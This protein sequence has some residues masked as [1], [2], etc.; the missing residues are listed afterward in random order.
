M[1]VRVM[2]WIFDNSPTQYGSR[3]VLLALADNA[4]DDGTRAF[5]SQETLAQKARLSI[6]QVRRCLSEL[7]STGAI[8]YVGLSPY[9]TDEYRVLMRDGQNVP[10]TYATESV[11]YAT[12]SVSHMSAKPSSKPSVKPSIEFETFWKAYPNKHGK[13]LAR[14]KWATLSP[15]EQ[16]KAYE[17][18]DAACRSELWLKENGAYIPHGSTYVNQ[19]RWEDEFTPTETIDTGGFAE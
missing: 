10:R 1:S 17:T 4:Q 9:G 3:C 13:A 18:L 5:P 2:T 8:E 15:E 11:T 12:E 14:K 7:M 6:R 16:K 19:R